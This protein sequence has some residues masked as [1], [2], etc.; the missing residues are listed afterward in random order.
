MKCIGFLDCKWN[1][2]YSVY[3]WITTWWPVSTILTLSAT[4]LAK[5]NC[6]LRQIP[7]IDL[8]MWMT[9]NGEG[10]NEI[11][12]SLDQKIRLETAYMK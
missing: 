8:K 5:Q 2:K 7:S 1:E 10:W 11:N 9:T 4:Q 3:Y 12:P 6:N